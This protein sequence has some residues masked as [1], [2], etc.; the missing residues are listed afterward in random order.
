MLQD[1][2]EKHQIK[3]QKIVVGVSGGADSLYAVLK[4]NEE[5]SPKYVEVFRDLSS[6][7]KFR[8]ITNPLNDPNI[9]AFKQ[10]G[11]PGYKS[12]IKLQLKNGEEEVIKAVELKFGA[13]LRK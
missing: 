12:D 6:K 10:L 5:L 1:F 8:G 9:S 2:L 13:E 3:P 11:L 4:A 7:K